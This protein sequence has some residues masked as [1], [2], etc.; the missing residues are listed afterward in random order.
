MCV[1][2]E[3]GSQVGNLIGHKLPPTQISYATGAPYCLTVSSEEAIIWDLR[4][5]SPLHQLT[6]H[7]RVSIKQVL[8]FNF[9]LIL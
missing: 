9:Q 8:L 1:C 7:I 5:D 6:L 2:L 3:S 4:S